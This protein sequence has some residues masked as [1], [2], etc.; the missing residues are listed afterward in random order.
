MRHVITLDRL[1][2]GLGHAVALRAAQ[3]CGH[4][5]QT[6]LPSKQARLFGRVGLAVI[7][8]PLHRRGGQL[9]TEALLHAFQHQVADIIA[10]VTDRARDPADGFA[11][12]A[13]QGE[14]HAQFG[15]VLAAELKAVR[16]LTRIAGL[17]GNTAFVPTR[18]A[19][20]FESTFLQL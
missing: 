6:D 14:G 13:I 5:L 9:I 10:A 20:L 3:R 11:I 7:A 17:H 1:H 15:A 2:K 18:H 16:A 8:E 12:T 19:G 4:R